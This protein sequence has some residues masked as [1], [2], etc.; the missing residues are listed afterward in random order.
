MW[1]GWYLSDLLRLLLMHRILLIKGTFITYRLDLL[2][3]ILLLLLRIIF[4]FEII[5]RDT[6]IGLSS[7]LRSF[8]EK[9][10]FQISDVFQSFNSWWIFEFERFHWR[11]SILHEESVFDFVRIVLFWLVILFLL[12]FIFHLLSLLDLLIANLSFIEYLLLLFN[13]FS[14]YYWIHLVYCFIIFCI[15]D[16]CNLPWHFIVSLFLFFC[17]IHLIVF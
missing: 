16:V 12:V 7:L 14:V 3:W 8:V 17:I 9:L 15:I 1:D 5:M 13:I 10:I 4:L 11:F 2:L 6:F